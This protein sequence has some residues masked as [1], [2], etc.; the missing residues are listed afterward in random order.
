MN[1][2]ERY[3]AQT[4]KLKVPQSSGSVFF[5]PRL[6]VNQPND[7]YEQE[8]DAM[9]DHVMRMNDPVQNTKPF[10]RPTSDSIRRKC[11]H[12]EDEEKLHRKEESNSEVK[13]SAELDSYVGSLGSS[14][15]TLP[16]SSRQ[17][18]EPRFGHD[19]SNV[20]IH[21]D[22]VA[23][24]SAQSVNAL[25]YTTGNNIVFNSGQY[26]PDSDGGKRL[27]AHELTHVMQQSSA[28]G[29]SGVTRKA[30]TP[31]PLY[32]ARKK[33]PQL[34]SGEIVV[35]M[36][37][38]KNPPGSSSPSSVSVTT[39]TG[40]TFGYASSQDNIPVGHHTGK[41]T[42]KGLTI[43]VE[44]SGL[45]LYFTGNDKSPAPGSLVFTGEFPIEVHDSPSQVPV[46][47]GG[48][49]GNSGDSS[50]D[51][52]KSPDNK[53][54][55]PKGNDKSD[56]KKPEEKKGDKDAVRG[57]EIDGVKGG[58]KDGV[59]GG[60]GTGDNEPIPDAVTDVPE[61]TKAPVVQ[62]NNA[63]EVQKLK[64]KGLIP[65]KTADDITAKLE[66][67]EVLSVDE[68]TALMDGLN[69]VTEKP[70]KESGPSKESWLKW[71]KFVQE[72][73]DKISGKSKTGDKGMTVDEVKE[74]IAK[75]KEYVGVKDMPK[76]DTDK[77]DFDP[78][79]RKSWNDLQQWEKDLWKEYLKK[80]PIQNGITD[81]ADLH[82]NDGMKMSMAL[83]A[84]PAYVRGGGREALIQL[85]NDPIFIGGTMVGITL[86]VAAWMAP[87]P[88]FSKATAA[89]I[90]TALLTLFTVSE[91]KNFA[92]AWM[93]L[94]DESSKAKNID[95]I[96][97]AAEHFGKAMGGIL[98]RVLVTIATMLAGKLLPGP[99]AAVEGPP[100]TGGGTGMGAVA[101]GPK[102]M[103]MPIPDAV[104]VNGIKVLADGTIVIVTNVGVLATAAKGGTGGGTTTG[105]GGSGPADETGSNQPK[106]EPTPE[107]KAAASKALEAKMAAEKEAKALAQLQQEAPDLHN[108]VTTNNTTMADGKTTLKDFALENPGLLKQM[109][110]KWKAGL[111]DGS[112]KTK[113]F[114]KYVRSRQSEFRGR[115]GELDDAFGRGPNEILVK[116]PKAEVT[117]PGTDSISYDTKADRIKLLD[118]K[119]VKPDA[120]VSKVSA[121]EKNL[122]KN[123]ADDIAD[124]K[125]YSGDPGVP[126]EIGEKVLP[127]LEAAKAEIDAYI[128][129]NKLAPEQ[130]GS[131]AV[132]KD[133]AKILDKHGIDRVVTLGGAGKGAKT[134]GKLSGDKGFKTE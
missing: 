79:K 82:I 61:D 96:E 67:N 126:K 86:Y 106:T 124:I 38:V 68:V 105:G 7:I 100:G 80:H 8:A 62:V 120:T 51:Q 122:P 118:N 31:A 132:Q 45:V 15:Q 1:S 108:E 71:A 63:A 123:L 12:C 52:P 17:F 64:D 85:V 129:K 102:G 134:S 28:P 97:E 114:G 75:Y 87:E 125:K 48:G 117:E 29:T 27:M 133:F 109:Y 112:I 60:T 65:A 5:Q 73:K 35:S 54:D 43:D 101:G 10:F 20:R 95:Q 37:V 6:T 66:K 40:R 4:E 130:L 69:K 93:R 89:T 53:K 16:E 77:K 57:G 23:A 81:D 14:G 18:F 36:R 3:R 128:L 74:I 30:F 88:I 121:L 32:L 59:K 70:E 47:P 46:G 84:S 90:T 127:R 19:F 22:S 55:T 91:I 72:N 103:T 50:G 34:Q 83:R 94:S 44:K 42:G 9:A 115:S 39:S 58:S 92:V 78:E 25:A 26:S 33:L 99:P 41:K 49:D 98:A 119:S 131:E 13:G 11:Q 76:G 116:S 2:T 21:T 24:K 107:E 104:P 111:A 56:E 113:D 110:A